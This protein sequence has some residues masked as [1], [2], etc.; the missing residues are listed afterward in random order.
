MEFIKKG[1][2][3]VKWGKLLNELF[4]KR[5][6]G[7]YGDFVTFKREEILPL[8]NQVEEFRKIIDKLLATEP[9]K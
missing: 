2:L 9:E 4:D 1:K 8:V 3:D 6:D 7:D 5:Q